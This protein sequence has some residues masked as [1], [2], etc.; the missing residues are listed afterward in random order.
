MRLISISL[1]ILHFF[2]SN[3]LSISN[4]RKVISRIAL[5]STMLTT[6]NF[7]S[8]QPTLAAS[9]YSRSTKTSI[10][11]YDY[12]LGDENSPSAKIGDRIAY[13]YKGSCS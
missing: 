9:E 3:A 7:I 5:T 8:I 6:T 1:L 11:Y 2:L 4:L 13:N 10:E 12:K